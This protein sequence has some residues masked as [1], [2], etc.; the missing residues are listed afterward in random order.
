[1]DY[2]TLK[3]NNNI[4]ENPGSTNF[5]Y[6]DQKDFISPFALHWIRI[7]KNI[8]FDFFSVILMVIDW[9]LFDCYVEAIKCKRQ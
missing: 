2:Q 9:L 3:K 7:K 4:N 1:M 5:N 6:Q 8:S